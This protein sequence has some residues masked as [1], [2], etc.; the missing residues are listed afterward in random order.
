MYFLV[1]FL[2]TWGAFLFFL[3]LLARFFLVYFLCTW[4]RFMFFMISRLL[5]KKVQLQPNKGDS[6]VMQ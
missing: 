5:I 3:L 1:Y 6:N 2:Y 4:E